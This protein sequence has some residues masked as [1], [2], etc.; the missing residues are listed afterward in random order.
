M[1]PMDLNGVEPFYDTEPS[2]QE[3]DCGCLWHNNGHWT[4]RCSPHKAMEREY[5]ARD[6]RERGKK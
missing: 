3:Q 5:D 2:Y 6:E 4:V 1:S